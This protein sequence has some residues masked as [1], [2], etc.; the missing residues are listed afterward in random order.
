M[1]VGFSIVF[2]IALGAALAQG[3]SGFGFGIILMAAMSMMGADL[4]RTS[5]LAT[6]LS[7]VLVVSLLLLSNGRMKVNWK[8]AGLMGLGLIVG[9]P[10][11]YRLLLRYGEM[12]V[13]RLIFGLV[14][15]AFALN[16]IC[17][18]HLKRRIPLIFAPAFGLCSGLLSGA[19]ASGGPPVVMY[20]YAQEDDPRKAI[21]TIQAVFMGGNLYRLLIVM[22][23]ARGISGEL[24]LRAALLAPVVVLA[25]LAGFRLAHR[26]S[27]RPFLLVVY[28]VIILSG[29]VN[30]YKGICGCI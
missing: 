18:P 12:P 20:L 8:Q 4:E 26:F 30:V 14:L 17:S 16:R 6:M 25:G 13:C 29:C 2:A 9:V 28:A 27:L 21:G 7:L 23:G 22:C 24:G 11:G 1:D 5:V 15:I 19:F 10:I 3:F